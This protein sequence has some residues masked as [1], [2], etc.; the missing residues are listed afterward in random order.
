MF[1]FSIFWAYLWFSQFML[2]WYANIPEEVT[3]Y[4]QRFDEYKFPFLGMIALNFVLPILILMNSDYKRLPWFIIM[5]GI[6]VLLGHYI[7]I[8]IMI[9][10][11]SVGS[12]WSFI[13]PEVIGAALF[14]LGLFIY[15]VFNALTKAPLKAKGSPFIKESEQFHY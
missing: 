7:D 2:I 6:L 10:P 11:G 15:I 13:S 12:N 1:G 8:Y 3:Y 4:V 9:T 5:A 14:F